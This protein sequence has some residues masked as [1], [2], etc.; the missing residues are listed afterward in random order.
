L[1]KLCL[2]LVLVLL[3]CCEGPFSPLPTVEML[4]S[5]PE[6]IEIEGRQYVLETY[7]WRD[8]MPVSPPDGKPLIALI[9]ITAVDLLPFP[10]ALDADRLWVV[11]DQ[12]FW[13]TEFSDEERPA[14]PN[15]KHQLEKIARDG[16]KWG[17]GIYVDV[18]VR[19]VYYKTAGHKKEYFLKASR[20]LI[21]RTD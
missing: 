11:N 6:Q 7:L 19:I 1:K 13:E 17:P 3:S 21:G 8:F 10:G 18:V 5:S 20:Q 12:Q 15:R 9:W 2:V 14:D 4:L 16:P